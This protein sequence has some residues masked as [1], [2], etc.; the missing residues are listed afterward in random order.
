[1]P[2]KKDISVSLIK[3]A[4][5]FHNNKYDYSNLEYKNNSTKVNI[6]CP[7]HGGFQQQPQSHLKHGCWECGVNKRIESQ[8]IIPDR[9]RK[10]VRRIRCNI[11]DAFYDKGYSKK[12]KT[13]KILGCSWEHFKNY[14]EDNPYGFKVEDDKMELDHIIPVSSAQTEEEFYKL[15][16]YENFQLLP[17]YYNRYIK[18]HRPYDKKD[19]EKWL[20]EKENV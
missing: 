2:N 3:K 14:L 8:R 16:H 7:I 12:T 17:M 18:R 1:M 20:K 19:F 15:N 4:L 11:S 6:I 10:I 5:K 9:L 13:Y